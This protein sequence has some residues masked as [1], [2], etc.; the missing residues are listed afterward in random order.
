MIASGKT[1]ENKAQGTDRQRSVPCLDPNPQENSLIFS[2]R[3]RAVFRGSRGSEAH[4]DTAAKRLRRRMFTA[5]ILLISSI[6]I[7]V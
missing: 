1:P 5:P 2:G 4:S 3:D 7:W 6:L